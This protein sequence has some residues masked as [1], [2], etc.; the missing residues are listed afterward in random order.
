MSR[1]L[2]VPKQIHIAPMGYEYD[3][4]VRPITEYD[5]DYAILIDYRPD[6]AGPKE[7][8]DRPDYHDD[9]RGDIHEAGIE[10]EVLTCDIFDLYSSLGMIAELAAKFQDHNVYVNLASGSK[11]TAIG[12]M[13][14]C[15]ATNAI[16]YYVSAESYAGGMESPVAEEASEPEELPKYH[17]EPPER[18]HIAVLD[19]VLKNEPVTKQDLIAFGRE[20]NLPFIAR[21]DDE[22]VQNP[23]RGYYRRLDS[24]IVEPLTDRAYIEVAAHSKYRYVSIT[25]SGKNTLQAFRYLWG[26]DDDILSDIDLH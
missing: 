10:V 9:V 22:G 6:D 16:P 15:M 14:A 20:E 13:I 2:W 11:V 5:A 23:M 21:Y 8:I 1:A 7:S 17:I 25:E 26:N 19:Y 18:Q 4:I 3:R 24:Q 12:G